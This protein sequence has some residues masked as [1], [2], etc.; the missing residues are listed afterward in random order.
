MFQG[1]S[2]LSREVTLPLFPNVCFVWHVVFT[3]FNGVDCYVILSRE[4]LEFLVEGLVVA[5]LVEYMARRVMFSSSYLR[6]ITLKGA[7]TTGATQC[8]PPTCT[9]IFN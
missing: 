9:G 8:P 7:T 2:I 3:V 6:K 1:S 4:S 5:F